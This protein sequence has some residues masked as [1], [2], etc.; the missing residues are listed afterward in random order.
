M[1]GASLSAVMR[2]WAHRRVRRAWQHRGLLAW[3]MLPLHLL[4]RAWRGG[5]SLAYRVGY[6]RPVQLPVPVVVVGNLTVGGTGKTPLVIELV[7]ALRSRGWTPGVVASGFGGSADGPVL[8]QPDTDPA[9]CGDE[10]LLVRHVADCPVAVGRDRIAAAQLLLASNADCDLLIADDGLQHR[11]LARDMEIVVVNASG[12]GNGWL[13]PAGPLRDPPERLEKVDAVVLHGV[14]P[15]VRIHSPFFRMQTSVRD[16]VSM[17][18]P[19]RRIDLEA[20]AREQREQHLRLL[21]VCAIGNPE[22]FFSMLREHGLVCDTVALP[23]HDTIDA[24]I[25]PPGRYDTILMTQ[26]DAVKC[27]RDAQ[28]C[29]DGRIWIVPLHSELDV[30]LIDFLA[31]RLRGRFHGSEAA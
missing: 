11:R 29:R 7:C 9:L 3:L 31:T 23:D 21:A 13:L 16:A 25:L 22:R 27:H 26:K 12:V 17:T 8:V 28:L 15:P 19:Q 1:S 2:A 18:E 30:G 14:V 6:R 4:H 5:R 20:L 24:A 10:P